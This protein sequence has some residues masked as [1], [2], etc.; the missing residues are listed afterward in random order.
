MAGS[1]I[2]FVSVA[3][4]KVRDVSHPNAIVP[5]KSLKQKMIKPAIKTSD[6]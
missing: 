1:K 4:I 5:P 3:V 6:V 2:K